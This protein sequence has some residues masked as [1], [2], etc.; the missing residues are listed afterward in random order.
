MQEEKRKNLEKYLRRLVVVR[1]SSADAVEIST[2]AL[3]RS[4]S[5]HVA[6][7]QS[8]NFGLGGRRWWA[9]ID[10]ARRRRSRADALGYEPSHFQRQ[11]AAMC[12]NVDA[13]P[14]P[15]CRRR[16]GGCAIHSS[17]PATTRVS[18]QRTGLE[19]ADAP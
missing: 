12:L 16:L 11:L 17:V 8:W 18:R 6:S 15:H 4:S 5:A 2:I 3:G 19:H 10:H 9:V 7:K 13:V 1:A 14:D